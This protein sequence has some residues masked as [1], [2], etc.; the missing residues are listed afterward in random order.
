MKGLRGPEFD[1]AVRSMKYRSFVPFAQLLR[2]IHDSPGE[3]Q[4][5]KLSP[6]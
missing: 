6:T 5:T 4:D 1:A 3:W 2:D